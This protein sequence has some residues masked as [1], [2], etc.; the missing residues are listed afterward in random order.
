M[1]RC[2][3]KKLF[4]LITIRIIIFSIGT[5]GGTGG[6]AGGDGGCGWWV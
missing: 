3:N 6:G 5:C 4:L 1:L 2:L